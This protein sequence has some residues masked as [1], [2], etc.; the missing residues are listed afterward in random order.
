MDRILQNAAGV[1][2]L[3][4]LDADGVAATPTG[5]VVVT[6]KDSAG[7]TLATGNATVAANV[8][9]FAI[10]AVNAAKL[11]IYTVTWAATVAASANTYT[12]TFEIV[13]GFLFNVAQVRAFQPELASTTKYPTARILEVR[14]QVEELF[15][16]V[17]RT[18]FRPKGRRVLLDGT[19]TDLLTLP[20]LYPRSIY[21]ASIAGTTVAT[22]NIVLYESGFLK[23]KTGYWT[24]GLGN[25]T[26]HYAYGQDAPPEP[27]VEAAIK[28]AKTRLIRSPVN[29][30]ATSESTDVGTFRLATAGRD[31]AVGFPEIDAVLEMYGSG[32]WDVVG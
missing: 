12:T 6:V 26:I 4:I 1:I 17:C 25:V 19:G 7:A 5:A 11:D 15:E 20:D 23:L 13:G 8:C 2:S 3:T 18:A 16:R 27:I 9:T 14:E 28:Y 29:D 30:R 10:T 22:D 21:T 31:G 32:N 24:A